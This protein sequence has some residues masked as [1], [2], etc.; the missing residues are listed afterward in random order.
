MLA[1]GVPVP[2]LVE[3]IESHEPMRVAVEP[4]GHGSF[5]SVG[6]PVCDVAC[7]ACP[8]SVASTEPNRVPGRGRSTSALPRGQSTRGVTRGRWDL[9]PW[10]PTDAHGVLAHELVHVRQYED[11]GDTFAAD[12]LNHELQGRTSPCGN[13]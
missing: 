7:P 9:V 10:A 8:I 3:L 13:P 11:V 6:L 1:A 4:L 12:Y 2:N 5:D